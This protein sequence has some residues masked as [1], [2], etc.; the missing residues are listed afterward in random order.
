MDKPAGKTSHDIVQHVRRALGIRAAGH[1]GTLDPFATGLLVVLVGRAT[2]LARFVEAQPKTYVA[3]GRLGIRTTTDDLTG[4]V[5]GPES[6]GLL[7]ETLVRDTLA[8]FLGT[9]AQRPPQFSA[10]RVGG[11]RSYRKARRGEAVELAD[12][13]ITV[14]AIDLVA[15]RPPEFD[16]R[17][18]VSP[19]TYVRAIARDLGEQLGVGS[20]LTRLRREAIGS[21]RVENAVSLE[22]LSPAAL[23]PPRGVLAD[24]PAVE[25]DEAGRDDVAHGRAVVDSG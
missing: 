17:V 8:G 12:V 19:G 20:H 5:I 1:T 15:Y 21:L 22:R 3:T 23:I 14:H 24:L 16:F 7:P 10:K 4:E 11:E 2:R 18:T 13:D 25:L 6:A 9:Q